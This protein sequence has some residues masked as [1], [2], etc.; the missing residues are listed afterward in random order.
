MKITLTTSGT[1]G[2]AQPFLALG[3]ELVKRRHRV[4]LVAPTN[5][6][7]W[8]MPGIGIVGLPFDAEEVMRSSP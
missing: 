2:D 6:T 4:R 7:S 1:R 5:V 3:A 8:K